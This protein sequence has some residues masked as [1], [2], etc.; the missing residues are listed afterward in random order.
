MQT[1]KTKSGQVLRCKSS[2]ETVIND[3]MVTIA[4]T[5]IDTIVLIVDNGT[6]TKDLHLTK[7]SFLAILAAGSFFV[8]E[9]LPNDF[10]KLTALSLQAQNKT[11]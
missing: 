3:R 9:S 8:S 5:E 10:A 11:I 1:I 7:D 4:H 2:I 6:E